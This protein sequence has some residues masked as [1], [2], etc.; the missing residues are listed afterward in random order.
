MTNTRVDI[1]DLVSADHGTISKKN[2]QLFQEHY[3]NVTASSPDW[4]KSNRPAGPGWYPDGLIPLTATGNNS[5]LGTGSDRSRSFNVAAGVNQPVWVDVT[6]PN[7]APAGDYT[8]SFI[9]QCDQ[10]TVRS[11]I[12]LHIWNFSLPAKPSLQS[13]FMIWQHDQA[14]VARTLLE[15][16]V[17]PLEASPDRVRELARTAGLRVAGLPF[18]SGADVSHCAMQPPPSL[19]AVRAAIGKLPRGLDLI[20]YSA[21]EVGNCPALYPML[22]EWGRV[23]HQA[24]VKNLVTMAPNEQL[25]DDGLGKGRSAVDIWAVLPKVYGAHTDTIRKAIAK[26]DSV[27]SYTTLVQDGYSPKWQVDFAPINFR[28]Q[29]GFLNQSLDLTGI[30]Y[31]RV[32]M[33]G[34][35]PWNG[36]DTTGTFSSANFPGEGVLVYPGAP[37]GVPGV[38]P[39]M[40][41]KWIRD[42][43]EDYEYVAQLRRLGYGDWARGV[44]ARVA[45]DWSNW[46][47]DAGALEAVRRELGDKLSALTGSETQREKPG[48]T[49][50]K[51]VHSSAN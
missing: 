43:V 22:R 30:L 51:A 33:W 42:G 35:D 9:V 1:S 25:L 40:R 12:A 27:W 19:G 8:G 41:L 38:L 48:T 45:K 2:I 18:W 47:Q 15:N 49:G 34:R 37:V 10:G 23:L 31:W 46:T 29:P 24:G 11:E 6:V 44:I 39:S 3:I 20:D 7:D 21:D 17:S 4:G 50:G 16:K 36:L 28:I 13:A 32:D 5:V 14:A 26:G